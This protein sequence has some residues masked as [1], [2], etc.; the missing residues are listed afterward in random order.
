VEGNPLFAEEIVSFLIERVM[1]SDRDGKL[2][3]DLSS[4]AAA[5]PASV[6]GV[7]SARVDRLDPKDRTLLQAAAA[8]GRRFDPQC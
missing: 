3:F 1:P 8:I 6:Q 5:V 4:V 2:G 7:L